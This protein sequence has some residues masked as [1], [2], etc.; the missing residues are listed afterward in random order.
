MMENSDLIL[1]IVVGIS[2]GCIYG[3]LGLAIGFTYRSTRVGNFGQAN[4][5]TLSAYIMYTFLGSLGL[6]LS[7]LVAIVASF[8]YGGA[9]HLFIIRKIRANSNVDTEFV[10]MI[11]TL[12]L[13]YICNGL[14]F[15]IGGPFPHNFPSFFPKDS[16][17][18]YGAFIS[19]ADLGVVGITVLLATLISLFFN[20][21]TIGIALQGA[22]ENRLAASLRGIRIN[23]MLTL[24][25]G[26][27]AVIGAISGVLI[28]PILTLTPQMMALV[29]IYSYTASV[30]GGIKSPIGTLIGGIFVGVIENI[31]GYSEYIGSELKT[32]AVFVVLI[33]V[34]YVKPRGFFGKAEL[35]RV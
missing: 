22:A 17:N 3:I 7:F 12:G 16:V 29:F 2:T 1:Q 25:W 9:I 19:Y 35:R 15:M 14:T 11:I 6:Y 27:S 26:I 5:S 32:V 4:M 30:I 18:I 10:S 31:A 21:T 34:L 24:S 13:L 33:L 20:H 23:H 28:A 8:I